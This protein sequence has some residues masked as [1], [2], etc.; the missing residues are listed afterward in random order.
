MKSERRHELEQNVL[1]TW[2]TSAAG[3]AKDH[4]RE[5]TTA[6]I[7]LVALVAALFSWRHFSSASNVAAWDHYFAAAQ[8]ESGEPQSVADGMMAVAEAE[9]DRPGGWFA[10]MNAGKNL[11]MIGCEGF[12]QDRAASLQVLQAAES[13]FTH[14]MDRA[15]DPAIRCE[16][17]RNRALVREM[18]AAAPGEKEDPLKAAAD[19]L[20]QL[21]DLATNAGFEDY[22][23]LALREMQRVTRPA[24]AEFYRQM[25][26]LGEA[27][28][29]PMGLSDTE[30]VDPG[31]A[32]AARL[33]DASGI[34]NLGSTLPAP[35][36]LPPGE[37]STTEKTEPVPATETQAT[38]ESEKP[39]EPAPEVLPPGEESTTE[40]TEPV[41]ATEISTDAPAAS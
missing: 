15:T 10:A 33:L 31:T 35:E 3:R 22:R 6:A 20:K 17:L 24:T 16:A 27:K 39:A 13:Q 7:V 18:F 36:V 26:T 19:D 38:T 25:V 5:L 4:S 34:L 28:M 30:M 40:K 29:P 1:A 12:L 41:P 23:T 2:A 11:L 8:A 37:E 32:E 9:R 14:V 21:E